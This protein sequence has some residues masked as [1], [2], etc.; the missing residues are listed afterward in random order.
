MKRTHSGTHSNDHTLT[1]LGAPYPTNLENRSITN[2]QAST[3]A[4]GRYF[5]FTIENLEANQHF[6]RYTCE[7][8]ESKN[9]IQKYMT[10]LQKTVYNQQMEFNKFKSILESVIYKSKTFIYYK[11]LLPKNKKSIHMPQERYNSTFLKNIIYFA[12]DVFFTSNEDITKNDLQDCIPWRFS[13]TNPKTPHLITF[14]SDVKYI[15]NYYTKT[16]FDSLKHDDNLSYDFLLPYCLI[17]ELLIQKNNQCFYSFETNKPRYRVLNMSIDDKQSMG[18]FLKNLILEINNVSY[19]VQQNGNL[20][21]LYYTIMRNM[22]CHHN[23]MQVMFESARTIFTSTSVSATEKKMGEVLA[24]ENIYKAID[25]IFSIITQLNQV[26]KLE[27]CERDMKKVLT[28]KYLNK[29]RVMGVTERRARNGIAVSGSQLISIIYTQYIIK[30]CDLL[31]QGHGINES[32]KTSKAFV[33]KSIDSLKSDPN[34]MN[35]TMNKCYQLRSG[36]Q[37]ILNHFDKYYN[38]NYTAI[39]TVNNEADYIICDDTVASTSNDVG[40]QEYATQVDLR[41]PYSPSIASTH[42]PVGLSA[43]SMSQQQLGVPSREYATSGGASSSSHDNDG[44]TSA[45][46]Y[47]NYSQYVPHSA[48]I[49]NIAA[50]VGHSS[51]MIQPQLDNGA[52]S[53]APHI[54]VFGIDEAIDISMENV[55]KDIDVGV[56]SDSN[57]D[58]DVV[59]VDEAIDMSKG[60]FPLYNP[61]S[62]IVQYVE[63]EPLDLSMPRR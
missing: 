26:K 57:A 24:N 10:Y 44:P 55:S 59:G 38:Y 31:L 9:L 36:F 46:Q 34:F 63:V 23:G 13:D 30:F 19:N 49:Y 53:N 32:N 14:Q 22:L 7:N 51:D 60:S 33:Y 62:G 29:L 40:Q 45:G 37:A 58:I 18:K 20:Y 21:Q 11:S 5:K 35:K 56:D 28:K 2:A 52:N 61:T 54:V 16:V 41:Q 1:G 17:S 27:L 47:Q 12:L 50:P 39:G 8:G 43:N 4:N 42:G 48:N 15:F 6:Q 3:S 25:A